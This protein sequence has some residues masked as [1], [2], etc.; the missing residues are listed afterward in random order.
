VA[1][2]NGLRGQRAG[3]GCAMREADPHIQWHVFVL[4]G[5]MD[6]WIDVYMYVCYIYIIC[7]MLYV[8][9]IDICMHV[10]SLSPSCI[11]NLLS[12][13]PAAAGCDCSCCRS[14]ACCMVSPPP[15][16]SRC[17]ATLWPSWA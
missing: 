12:T 8:I 2:G 13:T 5:W 14:A 17:A 3:D 6:G 16:T 7:Y 11:N 15:R 1:G 4:Q 9:Y 10:S